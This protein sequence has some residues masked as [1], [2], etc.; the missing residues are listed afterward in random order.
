MLS[1]HT[2]RAIEAG[3]MIRHKVNWSLHLNLF[4]KLL[5]MLICIHFAGAVESGA[6][7]RDVARNGESKDAT[8]KL[9]K[10]RPSHSN[11]FDVELDE[12]WPDDD[13]EFIPRMHLLLISP[14]PTPLTTHLPPSC[15]PSLLSSFHHLP[16]TTTQKVTLT[17]LN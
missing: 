13:C 11:E 5:I 9:V 1:V 14:S 3:E 4:A 15:L 16:P 12:P 6:N 2:D 17:P 8:N 10:R 7:K